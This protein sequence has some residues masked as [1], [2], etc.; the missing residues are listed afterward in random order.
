MPL[1]ERLKEHRRGLLGAAAV[2][3]FFA[4]WE[5]LLTYFVP[6]NPFFFTKPSLIAGAARDMMASG[7][8]W[9]DLSVSGRAFGLGLAAAVVVGIALGLVM[10]WQRRTEYALDPILTALYASPLVALAPLL[11]LVFGVGLAGK[12]A[13]VFL[14]AVFPFVFNTFAGVKSTDRLLINVVRAFGGRE[15]DLYFKVILP[16]VLPYVVAGA[17]I[18]IGRGLVGI[19]VG[20]FYAASEGLGFAIS[21]FGDTYRLPEMFAGIMVLMIVAVVL[22]EGMRKVELLLAPWRAGE[23]AR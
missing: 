2:L 15:R 14:L 10:G 13:L 20:E 7:T 1:S 16:T 17:R 12:A 9:H 22:T 6:L 19:I 8:L 4:G 5:L 23:E 18:A 21:R 11:I 3:A